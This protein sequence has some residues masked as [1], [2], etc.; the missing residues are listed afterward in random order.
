MKSFKSLVIIC[1]IVL[2]GVF[3][4]GCPSDAPESVAQQITV[5]EMTLTPGYSW[6][7]EE[8]KVY[9]P[10]AEFVTVTHDKFTAE[11]KIV[12]FVKPACACDGTKKL[13]PHI[14]KTL[15]SANVDMKNVEIWSMRTNADKHKYQPGI[16]ITTLPLV[17]VFRNGVVSGTIHEEEFNG[18]NA[19]SLM[20]T[21]LNQP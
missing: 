2:V 6:F 11:H 1:S 4:G 7:P 21:V 19:D 20:A 8:I 5:E 14:I 17:K 10:K 16:Q 18:S 15:Q 9:K 3:A 13:F 12:I